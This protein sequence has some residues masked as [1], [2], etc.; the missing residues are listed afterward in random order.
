MQVTGNGKIKQKVL[1]QPSVIL[2]QDPYKE[3]EDELCLN[4][5]VSR[6]HSVMFLGLMANLIKSV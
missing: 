5:Y 3:E 6:P 2:E 4:I 1:K